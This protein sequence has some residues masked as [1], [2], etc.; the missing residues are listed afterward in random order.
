MDISKGVLT[1]LSLSRVLL[2]TIHENYSNRRLIWD[3]IKRD[4]RMRYLGS[5]IGS[6]WNFIH[7]L[8]MISIY[9]IIFSRV[10]KVR[11]GGQQSSAFDFTIYL[12]AGQLP[13]LAF[14]EMVQRG[15]NQFFENANFIKKIAFPKEIIQTITTGSSAITLII[16]LTFYIL[17]LLISGHGLSWNILF[18]PLLLLMQMLF[19]SGLGVALGVFNVFLRDVQQILNIIFQIWFWITP[20]VYS[21]KLV[22]EKYHKFFLLN[23]IFPFVASYQKIFVDKSFPD[24]NHILICAILSIS[25]YFFGYFIL[26]K[27]KD[28]IADEL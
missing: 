27:L 18:L 14:Q 15:S 20:I 25:S 19:A 23:P 11:L 6:Y 3:L 26:Q 22:D 21:I 24:T 12:C 10:M 28:Q 5:A 13:W 7:P 2:S 17:L 8:A 16:S 9:T 4:F 1:V